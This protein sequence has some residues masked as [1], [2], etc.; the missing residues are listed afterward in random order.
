MGIE[1]RWI[2]SD[3]GACYRSNTHADGCRE[4]GLRHSFTRH[5]RPRTSGKAERFIE[6]FTSR[7]AH[8]AI[9]STSAE[10]NPALPG[11]LTHHNLTRQHGAP[12][13]NPHSSPNRAEQSC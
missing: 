1:P 5:Y 11:W 8:G 4:L 10:R 6:T 13:T 7:W 12:A 3:N 9:Y 2:L